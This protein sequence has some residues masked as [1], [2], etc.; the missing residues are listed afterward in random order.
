MSNYAIRSGLGA[1]SRTF[2]DTLLMR[3]TE[4][5]QRAT[6]SEQARVVSHCKVLASWKCC[7]ILDYRK[8]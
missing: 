4:L 3:S 7:L 2:R 1:T 6:S 8:S 5:N